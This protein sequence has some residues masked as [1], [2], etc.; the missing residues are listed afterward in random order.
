MSHFK[1][2]WGVIAAG[3]IA[4]IAIPLPTDAATKARVAVD[5]GKLP[6]IFEAN[7]GQTDARVKFLSRGRGYSLFLTESEAVLSLRG[8]EGKGHALRVKLLGAEAEPKMT[9]LDRLPGISNYFIGRDRAKWQTGVPHF[10]KVGYEG[11]Y[12]GIDLVFYGTNQRQLEYDFT[13]APGADPARIR[14]A[15][16]GAKRLEIAK[17]GDLIAHIAGGEVRFLKPVIYQE[18]GAEKRPVAGGYVL[19]DGRVT[20][21][22][23][24]YDRTK[25]LVIDPVLEY[26]TYLGGTDTEEY[27]RS[28]AVDGGGNAYVTGGTR[29]P[30]F[31]I[32]GGFQQSCT[33]TEGYSGCH[34]AFVTK[35]DPTGSTLVYST[36]L[37]GDSIENG[38]GIAVDADGN[39]Y[40]S[41]RIHGFGTNGF[42]TTD[43]AFQKTA[44]SASDGFFVKLDETGGLLYSTYLGGSRAESALDIAVDGLGRAHVTGETDSVDDPDTEADEGFPVTGNAVASCT[45]GNAFV[46]VIDP[47]DGILNPADSLVYGTCLGGLGGTTRGWAIAADAAGHAYVTGITRSDDFPVTPGAFQ[48]IRPGGGEGAANYDAFVAMIDPDLLTSLVYASYLGGSTGHEWSRAIALE[49]GCV[50]NCKMYITGQTG[51]FDFPTTPGVPVPNYPG[52]S[53]DAFLSVI[54]PADGDDVPGNDLIYST[55]LGDGGGAGIAVTVMTEDAVGP[56]VY[57]T[58]PWSTAGSDE[59]LLRGV[60]EPADPRGRYVGV[61]E[62]LGGGLE[63]VIFGAKFGG[64][65]TVGRTSVGDI[66]VDSLGNAYLSGTTLSRDFPTTEGAF[67]TEISEEKQRGKKSS[68]APP[69]DAFIVK[70]AGPFLG[71][72]EVTPISNAAPHAFD[73]IYEMQEDT[74]LDTTL[75]VPPRGVLENDSDPDGD[76]LTAGLDLGKRPANG[77]VTMDPDGNFT[78]TPDQ[79]FNGTDSFGYRA[80]DGKTV[81]KATVTVEVILVPDDDPPIARA[82][83]YQALANTTLMVSAAD[84]VLSNDEDPDGDILTAVMPTSPPNGTVALAMNGSF[85]YTPNM[86]FSGTDV[87]EYQAFDGEFSSEPAKVTINVSDGK[88]HV[89][90]LD[91]VSRPRKSNW[92]AQ[93]VV[94]VHD[95]NESP[96]ADVRVEFVWVDSFGTTGVSACTT[97]NSSYSSG[98]C[99]TTRLLSNG[100][101]NITY[102][103]TDL[104]HA[105]LTYEPLAN[106]DPDGDSVIAS[107]GTIS[108]TFKK[109]KK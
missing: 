34:D 58:G 31:P 36:Y 23:A 42:P 101:S 70:I 62:P 82:D 26:S 12:P 78:Y 106:H 96:L 63:D 32:V 86:D 77:T 104:I 28:I 81:T 17:S 15:I 88:M 1:F 11:V 10:A 105:S 50:S 51:S 95:G 97:R 53:A 108:I 92:S 65:S 22:I 35:L 72:G 99:T 69:P 66:G 14:L 27:V 102:T 80:Y 49:P 5:Y 109:P 83:S 30:D 107:D 29:S 74:T 24:A 94:T 56:R 6:L 91:D 7:R 100:I 13:V 57:L 9:G 67:Q 46:V 45:G 33:D 43:L 93:V 98:Q 40:V 90:D 20:F 8:T 48:E 47:D 16:E 73:D 71:E 55:F 75:I 39:A 19:K 2:F 87:F 44:G 76:T 37:G 4:A 68:S 103:V 84:G 85:S 25:P 64:T 3:L 54:D 38:W 18:E 89:G 21:E 41:G 60:L 52:S 59:V 61:I 79:N